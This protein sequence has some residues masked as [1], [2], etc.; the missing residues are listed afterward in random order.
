MADP[1]RNR[2]LA[3]FFLLLAMWI[4]GLINAFKHSQDAWSSVGTAGVLLS[5]ISTLTALAAGWIA[6]SGERV[7]R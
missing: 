7:A 2:A 5:A 4:A 3:Y 6:Y 1:A